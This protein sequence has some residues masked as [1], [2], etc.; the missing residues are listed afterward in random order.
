MDFYK[1]WE[2]TRKN[3]VEDFEFFKEFFNHT[4]KTTLPLETYDLDSIVSIIKFLI[5]IPMDE[6]IKNILKMKVSEFNAENIVQFSNFKHAYDDLPSLLLYENRAMNYNE[7]GSRIMHSK[8]DFAC[9]KYGENHSKLAKEMGFVALKRKG[10]VL[11]ELTALGSV[12]ASLSAEDKYKLS[13]R[14]LTRNILTRNIIILASTDMVSY[15]ELTSNIL[16]YSTMLRRKSNVKKVV[17]LIL[18]DS[19]YIHIKNNIIW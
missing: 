6:F 15:E 4:L 11:V 10:M 16:S 1:A 18:A 5:S 3:E 12:S 13:L 2:A 7:I 17:E 9:K 19:S 8:G 14:M